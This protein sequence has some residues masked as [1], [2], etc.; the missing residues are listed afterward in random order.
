MWKRREDPPGHGVGDAANLYAV[1]QSGSTA[2]K[3]GGRAMT[4][5]VLASSVALLLF[6]GVVA[7]QRGA[8]PMPPKRAGLPAS[9]FAPPTAPPPPPELI[10]EQIKN[11]MKSLQLIQSQVQVLNYQFDQT[12]A[13]LQ[14]KLK[15]LE[16]DGYDL[17]IDN[18]QYIAKPKTP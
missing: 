13:S 4:R 1:D 9:P 5:I 7:A 3:K 18:W 17:N 8:V 6:F 15:T 12:R 10:H 16:R 11:D 2:D 14:A